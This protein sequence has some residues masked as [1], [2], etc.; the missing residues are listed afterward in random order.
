MRC[1][2][3][4]AV[5]IGSLMFSPVLTADEYAY[6]HEKS[7]VN[8]TLTHLNLMT[9]EGTFRE[10]SGNFEFDVEAIEDSSVTLVIQAA[11]LDSANAIRD[12]QLRSRGHFWTDAYPEIT[13]ASTAFGSL[14]DNRF[15]IYGDLTIKNKTRNIVFETELL[16]PLSD[17]APGKPI[18]F[19]TE[20]HIN[21]RDFNLG[22]GRWYD[23][24]AY[25][26]SDSVK[27]SLEVEGYQLSRTLTAASA[28]ET[29]SASI[30][31]YSRD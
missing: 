9:V 15:S 21:R 29:P 6:D 2:T 31:S 23:P 27:I 4:T 14:H 20:T 24:I 30:P 11:S 13:F 18:R 28:T 16:T 5:L 12:A 10:F 26:T 19:R 22:T 17:I 1:L 25:V 7:R 3:M 8:F